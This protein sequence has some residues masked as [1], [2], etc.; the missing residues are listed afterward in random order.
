MKLTKQRLKEIIKEE[1][2]EAYSREEVSRIINA[3]KSD[4]PKSGAQESSIP[5][6]ELLVAITSIADL[7]DELQQKIQ[8]A[9]HRN[10]RQ[11]PGVKE[12][13]ITLQEAKTFLASIKI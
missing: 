1:L 3:P 11:H 8:M 12:A 6:S 4:A 7:V 5:M 13:L 10:L 2:K 9:A